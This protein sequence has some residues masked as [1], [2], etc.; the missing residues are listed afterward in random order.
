MAVRGSARRQAATVEVWA[1]GAVNALQF[2]TF[3]GVRSTYG[4]SSGGTYFNALWA[5]KQVVGFAVHTG[6]LINGIH[7]CFD[8]LPCNFPTGSLSGCS[9]LTLSGED[10]VLN[11][12]HSLFFFVTG[13]QLNDPLLWAVGPALPAPFP[14]PASTCSLVVTPLV[15]APTTAFGSRASLGAR[16]P[17][18]IS[19][20]T[21]ALQVLRVTSIYPFALDASNSVLVCP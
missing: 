18:N 15:L 8:W 10:R 3:G 12:F 9:Q 4:T 21:V 2:T 14:L 7:V 17:G 1:G 20:G 13:T 19:G 5:G 16:L 11:E 6:L